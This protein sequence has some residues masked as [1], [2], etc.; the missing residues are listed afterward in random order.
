MCRF[1]RQSKVLALQSIGEIKWNN[2]SVRKYNF[3]FMILSTTFYYKDACYCRLSNTASSHVCLSANDFYYSIIFKD[4]L[5]SLDFM[6][7]LF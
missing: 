6:S 5:N 4:D 7:C 1:L 3:L 2:F